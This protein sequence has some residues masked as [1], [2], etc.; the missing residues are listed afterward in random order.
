MK[1]ISHLADGT[2]PESFLKLSAHR[3][4]YHVWKM[5]Y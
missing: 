2:A 3:G 4:T 5:A 1:E